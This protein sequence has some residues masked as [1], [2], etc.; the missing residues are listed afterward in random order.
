LLSKSYVY[1]QKNVVLPTVHV[2]TSLAH[3][4]PTLL[5]TS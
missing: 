1:S 4:S 5:E 3:Q 2:L